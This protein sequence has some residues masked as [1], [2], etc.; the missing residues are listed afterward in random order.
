MQSLW[1]N[2]IFDILLFLALRFLYLTCILLFQH[3]LITSSR[4]WVLARHMG[5]MS[6]TDMAVLD[7]AF[8]RALA[9]PITCLRK[10]GLASHVNRIVESEP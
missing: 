4:A 3:I 10:E 5:F 7:S 8:S 2:E 9:E 6:N 1:K